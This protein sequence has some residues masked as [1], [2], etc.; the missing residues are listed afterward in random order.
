M[1]YLFC[2]YHGILIRLQL[3]VDSE[4]LNALIKALSATSCIF[5]KNQE[6]VQVCILLFYTPSPK[7][8]F[9]RMHKRPSVHVSLQAH[10]LL[11]S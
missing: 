4:N 2:V 10:L 1:T 6:V 3:V 8:K 5:L 7:L 11:N 9:E